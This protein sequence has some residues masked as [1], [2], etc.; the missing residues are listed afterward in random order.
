MG[1]YDEANRY[2]QTALDVLVI[3]V[4]TS[5]IAYG[6]LLRSGGRLLAQQK[7]YDTALQRLAD[8]YASLSAPIEKVKTLL[9]AYG[10]YWRARDAG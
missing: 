1:R 4:G 8:S 9:V 3:E 2:F 10:V 6:Q 7:Q 5:D